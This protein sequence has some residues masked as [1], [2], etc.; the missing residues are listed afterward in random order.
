MKV[1]KECVLCKE[2]FKP[3]DKTQKYCSSQ[4]REKQKIVNANN[5]WKH[6]PKPSSGLR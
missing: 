4:C 6:S 1:E 2:K 3:Y 5:K